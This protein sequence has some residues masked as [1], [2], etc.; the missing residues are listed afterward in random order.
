MRYDIVAG[1]ALKKVMKDQL[2]H[3]IPF[4]EDLSVGGFKA[5][6]FSEA[7]LQE[8][9]DAHQVPLSLYKEKLQEFLEMLSSLRQEDEVHLSFGEDKTC[10]ANRE[11]LM[12]YLKDKV[13]NVRLHIV[14]E[15][16]G[17]EIL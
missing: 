4:N 10:V 16:T 11:F 7:F 12:E 9:A 3:P 2:P 8:R 14:N 13:M 17:E 15:Y 5:P 6:P 1:Q